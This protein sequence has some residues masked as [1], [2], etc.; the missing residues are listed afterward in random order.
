MV[1]KWGMGKSG[2]IGNYSLLTQM[3]EGL[4]IFRGQDA[5]YISEDIREKLNSDVQQIL[6]ECLQEVEELL[7][8]ESALLDRFTQELLAKDEI[9]Y[10]EIEAIFKEFGKT[11]PP[12]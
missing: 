5:S 7:K 6:N 12:I 11:R 3:S 1:W 8:K 4:G 2:L 10:D 9:N